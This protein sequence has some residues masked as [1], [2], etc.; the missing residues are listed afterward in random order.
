M[1][2]AGPVLRPDPRLLDR[3]AVLVEA[4]TLEGRRRVL[5]ISGAPGA[6]KTTLVLAVLAAAAAD[7]R[8]AGRVAHVP[9]DG[10]HLP[11]AELDRLGRRHRKG[12]PDTFDVE[13]YAAT[14]TTARAT[15]RAALWAPSFDHGVGEPEPDSIEVPVG[16]DLVL[17]EGNYLLL[18]DGGWPTVRAELDE[19]WFCDLAAEQRRA[20]LVDRHV[21]TGR[22]VDDAE[23][24]VDRSDEAN[25]R[26]VV[27][28]R[29][30]A[31][32]VVVDGLVVD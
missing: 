32:V 4:A 28:G 11:N 13:A 6:G 15:P 29:D 9:M 8:L 5:G 26:L 30:R 10:Y 21:L 3:C 2:A 12:A 25:A 7:P 31:D 17:T 20:R 27:T 24:W 14:L 1:T 16:A 22:E 19:V 18:P 23:A